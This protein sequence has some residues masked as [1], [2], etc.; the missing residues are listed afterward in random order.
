MAAIL[1]QVLTAVLRGNHGVPE[2]WFIPVGINEYG[3]GWNSGDLTPDIANSDWPHKLDPLMDWADGRN[4]WIR[5][6]KIY[7]TAD[8][9]LKPSDVKALLNE[10]D[11]RRRLR[12]EKAHALEAMTNDLDRSKSRVSIPQ[13]VKV[14][15]WQRDGGRCISCD[16]QSNLEFDH[17]IPLAMGGSNTMRNL[18][19]LCEVCNRRKGAT[20]G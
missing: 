12:L 18:Q 3:H 13:D 9:D 6:Q 10:A 15:V 1:K 14:A 5:N 2:N 8:A 20:L 16:S 17:V 19:L 4:Y 7:V 11:N